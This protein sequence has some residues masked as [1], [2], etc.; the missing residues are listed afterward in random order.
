MIVHVCNHNQYTNILLVGIFIL[1]IVDLIAV[2][3]VE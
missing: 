1:S 3:I 2:F